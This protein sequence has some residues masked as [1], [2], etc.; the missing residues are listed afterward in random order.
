MALKFEDRWIVVIEQGGGA[1]VVLYVID[2]TID[3]TIDCGNSLVADWHSEREI[4]AEQGK[5]TISSKDLPERRFRCTKREI[6]PPR[7]GSLDIGMDVIEF[8]LCNFQ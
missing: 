4:A 2:R 6:V 7:R 8:N 3:G 5:L 1:E